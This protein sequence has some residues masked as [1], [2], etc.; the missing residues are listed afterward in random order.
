MTHRE[1]GDYTDTLAFLLET[2]NASQ[3]KI[4]G[5]FTE[6][7]VLNGSDKF[8][9]KALEKGIGKILYAPPV[10]LD[11]RVARHVYTIYEI[12]QA[13]N[14]YYGTEQLGELKVNG[15][16]GYQDVLTNGI[17]HYLKEIKK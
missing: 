8:Y 7:L 4:R 11:E 6:E 1:L 2:S 9:D 3:G 16:P 17:G 15:F 5:A 14:K 13:Y 10:S 12:I